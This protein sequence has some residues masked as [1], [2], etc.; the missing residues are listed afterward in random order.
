MKRILQI[1]V[2]LTLL[3]A[4]SS[5]Q[6]Q[7]HAEINKDQLTSQNIAKNKG[8]ADGNT[9]R[10]AEEGSANTPKDANKEQT[11]GK[12]KLSAVQ[13]LLARLGKNV[14]VE[15]SELDREVVHNDTLVRTSSGDYRFTYKTACLNDS[16]VAQEM[17]N[18][19]EAYNK[20]YR[21]LHNYETSIVMRHNGQP[22]GSKIISKDLFQN[23]MPKEF[24]ENSI[25]KHPQ[26]VRFDE[27]KNE[28]I[29]QFLVGIPATDYV[30]LAGVNLSPR[31]D[32]RIIDVVMPKMH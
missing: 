29:F 21:L 6:Q 24:L 9:A 10:D 28:A 3:S 30:I 19:G 5:S 16:L 15:Y 20:S 22:S 23:K 18:Y 27:E 12:N 14:K 8:K 1:I 13:K 32:V 17:F 25:I 7:E 31:G 26:F 4:C 2:C 11:E